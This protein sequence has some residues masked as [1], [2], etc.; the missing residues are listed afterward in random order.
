MIGLTAIMIELDPVLRSHF[1]KDYHSEALW[2]FNDLHVSRRL[3]AISKHG[4]VCLDSNIY[5]DTF[6]YYVLSA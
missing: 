5:T 3:I 2:Q 4:S 1:S 6:S